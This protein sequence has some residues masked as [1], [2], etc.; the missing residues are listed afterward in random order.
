VV[1]QPQQS[2]ATKIKTQTMREIDTSG[3]LTARLLLDMRPQHLNMARHL[4]TVSLDACVLVDGILDEFVAPTESAVQHE[5]LATHGRP[6]DEG[7]SSD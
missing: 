3:L 5:F 1:C 6:S 4:L 2:L 7:C